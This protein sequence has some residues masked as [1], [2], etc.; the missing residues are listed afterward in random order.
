[1]VMK[2][3]EVVATV[4]VVAGTGYGEAV[5]VFDLGPRNGKMCG[6]PGDRIVGRAREGD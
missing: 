2:M 1:M 3:S 5:L 4:E 6:T